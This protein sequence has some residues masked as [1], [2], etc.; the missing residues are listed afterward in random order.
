MVA[1]EN[2]E[3]AEFEDRLAFII[4]GVLFAVFLEHMKKQGK[5]NKLDS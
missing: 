5:L 2:L 4:D 1:E 3:N